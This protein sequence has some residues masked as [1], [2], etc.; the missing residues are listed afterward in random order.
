MDRF[1]DSIIFRYN[2]LTC[3]RACITHLKIFF[4]LFA[5]I[6]GTYD[7]SVVLQG[8]GDGNKKVYWET[9][10]VLSNP[11]QKGADL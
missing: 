2:G 10:Q 4:K 7:L 8:V 9:R 3:P 5:G 6:T 1:F 11:K